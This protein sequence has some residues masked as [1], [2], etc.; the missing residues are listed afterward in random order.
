MSVVNK[1]TIGIRN[2]SGSEGHKVNTEAATYSPYAV[3][4]GN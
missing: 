2:Y 4:S 1:N 3:I